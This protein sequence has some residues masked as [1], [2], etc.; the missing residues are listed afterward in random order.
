MSIMKAKRLN[1][2]STGIFADINE[3]KEELIR[4][5]RKIY[6]LSIGTPDF[7]PAAHIMQAVMESASKPEEY[8]YSLRDLP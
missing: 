3:K 2:F 6:N 4:Q 8:V 1:H 7:A 5:G